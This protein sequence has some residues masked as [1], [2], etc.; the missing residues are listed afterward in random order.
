MNLNIP[1]TIDKI[2]NIFNKK[3]R[4]I[5]KDQDIEQL[6][7]KNYSSIISTITLIV[8][9]ICILNSL[10]PTFFKIDSWIYD[11]NDKLINYI[12]S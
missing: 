4:N 3:T 1:N 6:K 9:A 10:F 7:Y 8:L 5:E 2:I 11:L 12:L